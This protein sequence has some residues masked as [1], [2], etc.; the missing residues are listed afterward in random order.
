MLSGQLLVGSRIL[1]PKVCWPFRS[2]TVVPALHR[3]TPS[4]PRILGT[5]DQTVPF[6]RSPSMSAAEPWFS[7]LSDPIKHYKRSFRTVGVGLKD[8]VGV[9]TNGPNDA[10]TAQY[11]QTAIHGMLS[12]RL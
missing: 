7:A 12:H 1:F 11:N 10:A 6:L 5:V 9:D 8:V 3:L 4:I 2:Q